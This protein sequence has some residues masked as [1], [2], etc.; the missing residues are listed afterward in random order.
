MTNQGMQKNILDR[1]VTFLYVIGQLTSQT[2]C[3]LSH[4]DFEVRYDQ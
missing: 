1:I 2:D 4:H 3:A